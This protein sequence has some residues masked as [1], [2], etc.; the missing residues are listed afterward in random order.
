MSK[1]VFFDTKRSLVNKKLYFV[2]ETC[3]Q[4]LT[5]VV[6][7]WHSYGWELTRKRVFQLD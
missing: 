1:K 5:R 4:I 7:L 2:C 6:K 3:F